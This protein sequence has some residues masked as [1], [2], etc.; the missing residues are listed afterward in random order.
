M[1]TDFSAL[2]TT[3][4]TVMCVGD[5]AG[6]NLAC[7]VAMRAIEEG[8]QRA[9]GLVMLYPVLMLGL[10]PSPSRVLSLMDPLLPLGNLQVMYL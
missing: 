8:I 2:Q 1:L 10:T 9:S 7:V 3:A 5:S 6:G 4:E